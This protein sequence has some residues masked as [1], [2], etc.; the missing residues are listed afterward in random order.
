MA[1]PAA[2]MIDFAFDLDGGVL[3]AAYPFALWAELVHHVPQLGDDAAAGVLPLR[4]AESGEKILLTRRA[5]LVLRLPPALA[6]HAASL[7]GLQLDIEGSTL[8]LGA[9]KLREIQP[10]ST[11]H[12]HLV[13]GADDEA[14]FIRSVITD[15][16]AMGIQG[17]LICGRRTSLI[18][19]GRAIHG[20]SLVIHD[21]KPEASLRLQYTGLGSDRRYGCGVFVPYKVITGL[22]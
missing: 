21:L 19:G 14:E 15:L 13:T 1:E 6:G 8:R 17:K 16:A 12:A 2:E 4:A 11:L 3:S 10:Y 5:K 18:G 7:S 20:F 22:D 9:G